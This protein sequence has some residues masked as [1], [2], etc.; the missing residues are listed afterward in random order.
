VPATIEV[1]PFL[2]DLIEAKLTTYDADQLAR[3][4]HDVLRRHPATSAA[5]DELLAR[6]PATFVEPGVKDRWIFDREV[7]QKIAGLLSA[8][9]SLPNA[10]HR[11]LFRV[12]VGHT[13]IELSNVVVN[14]KGRRYRGGW[15]NRRRS[16]SGV[17]EAFV[18]AAK[19]AILDIYQ[20]GHRPCKGYEVRRGDCRIE[21]NG[22]APC[23]LAVFSPPY[24]NS[25]DYTDVYNVEL[26]MLGYLTDSTS[27]QS[28]RRATISS[29]VQLSR[30]FAEQPA[31][32]RTLDELLS[33][34]RERRERLWDRRIPEMIGAYFA[35]I[36]AILD[37]LKSVI[38]DAGR[39]WL[40]VG[41]SRYAD[42][43]VGTAQVIAEL[44]PSTGWEVD[45]VEPCRSMRSSAQQGGR[46]ELAETLIV[47]SRA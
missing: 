47:L 3:D 6:L 8:I 39:A 38:T 5:S 36:T 33:H 43:T 20:Y 15:Q 13:L 45:A 29:H 25:F 37:Q 18:D 27:N 23:D 7:A 42:V 2:A 17:S 12:V 31:G 24:P 30:D 21:L 46:H 32:S 22:I 9:E 35:D 4:V 14:G 26:W 44:A 19:Q 1:N 40:V 16:A 41:D 11:R 28:L 10:N 34:L